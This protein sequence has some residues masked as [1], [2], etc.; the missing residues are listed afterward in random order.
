VCPKKT[1]FQSPLPASN[2]NSTGQ[3]VR[4]L[5]FKLELEF[6]LYGLGKSVITIYRH[7]TP[8]FIYATLSTLTPFKFDFVGQWLGPIKI[9]SDFQTSNWLHSVTNTR[10]RYVPSFGS[11]FLAKK[12]VNFSPPLFILLLL[13]IYFPNHNFDNYIIEH[14]SHAEYFFL[15]EIYE[16]FLFHFILA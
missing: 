10:A 16:C 7:F 4:S 1:R 12:H 15:R 11:L 13:V 5:H 6:H 3:E 14:S 2:F 9:P 8:L